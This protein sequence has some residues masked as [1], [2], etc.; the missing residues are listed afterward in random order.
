MPGAPNPA[1]SFA[2]FGGGPYGSMQ[3]SG[4]QAAGLWGQSQNGGV[5]AGLWGGS[6]M[7]TWGG[8]LNVL[9]VANPE[10][11]E[12]VEELVVPGD[13]WDPIG[14]EPVQTRNRFEVLE[15]SDGGD[16]GAQRAPPGDA[17]AAS[18]PPPP[19][20]EPGQQDPRGE[21]AKRR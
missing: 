20:G 16:A 2:A 10:V 12:E 7:S 1:T 4:G 21:M 19:S 5:A 3:T 13:S 18:A 11:L 17:G 6:P 14:A 8:R 15:E 9:T